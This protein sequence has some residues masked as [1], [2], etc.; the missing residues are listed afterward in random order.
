M[1]TVEEAEKRTREGLADVDAGRLV[2][3][4]LVEAWAANLTAD[5]PLPAPEFHQSGK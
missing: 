2:D 4:Q 5:A 3:H 1:V